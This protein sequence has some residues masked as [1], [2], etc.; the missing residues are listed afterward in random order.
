MKLK[1]G[2]KIFKNRPRDAER[3]SLKREGG[4]R[5]VIETDALLLNLHASTIAS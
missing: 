3:E 2:Y 4:L 1:S 5:A